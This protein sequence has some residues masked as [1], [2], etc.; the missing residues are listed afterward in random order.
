[1]TGS[2]LSAPVALDATSVVTGGTAVNAVLATADGY[3][4]GCWIQ[5]DPLATT[6]LIVDCVGVANSGVPRSTSSFL[7]P[8]Q[9]WTSPGKIVHNISVVSSDS[10]HKFYGVK[11]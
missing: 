11:Y 3:F 4:N 9:T 1:M 10:A 5:N 8:G 7:Q 2:F 6:L